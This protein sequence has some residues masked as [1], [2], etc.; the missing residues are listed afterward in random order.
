MAKA[1]Q[2]DGARVVVANVGDADTKQ[3]Q[4]LA[5]R[6]RDGLG[7]GVA[8]L[9]STRE[10]KPYI[11]VA[12]SKDLTTKVQA[13]VVVKEVAPLMGGNGGGPATSASG[14]GKEPARLGDALSSAQRM[15]RERLMGGSGN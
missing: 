6:V 13:G 9:G 8:I 4:T 5:D 10:G 11:A 3:L 7:T 15:V 12:V 14:G 2:L 1:E